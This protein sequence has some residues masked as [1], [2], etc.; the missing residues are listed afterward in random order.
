M[1]SQAREGSHTSLTHILAPV[2]AD[3]QE[4]KA[5]TPESL[6]PGNLNFATR[7][8]AQVLN[9]KLLP[10]GKFIGDY[11]DGIPEAKRGVLELR[12]CRY[13]ADEYWPLP[14][15][16]FTYLKIQEKY[17]NALYK[18]AQRG[19]G[20]PTVEPP[21]PDD[22]SSSHPSSEDPPSEAAGYKDTLS[23]NPVTMSS[24]GVSSVGNRDLNR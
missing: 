11:L 1:A 24:E 15:E 9:E 12:I 2:L 21:L 18:K 8:H 5:L 10:I 23:Q 13:I 16:N 17:R 14:V 20:G 19:T 3:L 7:S 4:L 22:T 6:P